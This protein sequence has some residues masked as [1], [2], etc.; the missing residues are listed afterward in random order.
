MTLL[1]VIAA[2]FVPEGFPVAPGQVPALFPGSRQAQK[3]QPA[4]PFFKGQSPA[5]HLA[6]GDAAFLQVLQ[7]AGGAGIRHGRPVFHAEMVR[8]PGGV[9]GFPHT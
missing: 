7:A 2:A 5:P 9:E 6:D 4:K 3:V 8:P 1:R